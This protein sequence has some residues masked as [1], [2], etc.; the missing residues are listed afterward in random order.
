MNLT[1]FNR[2]EKKYIVSE[3]TFTNLIK[4]FKPYLDKDDHLDFFS[5]YTI[6]NIYYDTAQDEIIKQSVSKP[7]FKQKLRLRGYSGNKDNDLVFLELKKKLHGYVNKRRT[8]ISKEDA[9]QLIHY[10]IKPDPQPY[11]N[12]QVINELYYYVLGK[13]LIPRI[14]IFYDRVAY[15]DKNNHDIRITFDRHI[16]SRRHDISLNRN[17][18]DIELMA[19]DQYLMEI[20]TSSSIPLWLTTILTKY[21]L[22][23]SSFSKYGSEFY[24]YLITQRKGD[25]KCLNPYSTY[26]VRQSL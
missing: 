19:S 9:E 16:T 11:H 1:T 8:L 15:F 7:E 21:K 22:Y 4:D 23:S 12:A 13:E 17:D 26:Q 24:D 2:F 18:D 25:E 20:K 14:A 10:K 5:Y 3:S 6:Y